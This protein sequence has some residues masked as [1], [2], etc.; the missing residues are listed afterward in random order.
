[1]HHFVS[2]VSS[3]MDNYKTWQIGFPVGINVLMS[4]AAYFIT[5]RLIPRLKDKFIKANLYGIDMNK[6]ST[7]Q[8]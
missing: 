8:V 3:S 4:I 2:L 1:M 7:N 5:A 6:R